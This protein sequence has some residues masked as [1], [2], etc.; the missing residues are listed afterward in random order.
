M[1]TTNTAPAA[2]TEILAALK[3]ERRDIL[4]LYRSLSP[5]A[6]RRW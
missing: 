5:M 3:A 6:N 4:D 1:A 2:K